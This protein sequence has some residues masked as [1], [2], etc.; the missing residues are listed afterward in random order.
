MSVTL[1]APPDETLPHA[2]VTN[3]NQAEPKC[4]SRT[5]S[6]DHVR[7][8]ESVRRAQRATA[9]NPGRLILSL[10]LYWSPPKFTSLVWQRSRSERG[11]LEYLWPDNKRA[12]MSFSKLVNAA[13]HSRAI[14]ALSSLKSFSL[15]CFSSLCVL[16]FFFFFF[17]PLSSCRNSGLALIIDIRCTRSFVA[18]FTDI[19]T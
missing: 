3:S 11:R 18:V 8:C 16:G 17:Q 12:G 13:H 5:N 6:G 2:C 15:K 14:S 1:N 10:R 19:W 7:S 9:P 4:R